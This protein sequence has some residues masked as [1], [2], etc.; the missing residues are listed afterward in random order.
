[1]STL[2]SACS[3]SPKI[4]ASIL[5]DADCRRKEAEERAQCVSTIEDE[6]LLLELRERARVKQPAAIEILRRVILEQGLPDEA[7]IVATNG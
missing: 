2:S 1:M 4:E 3:T 7:F 6:L 5:W